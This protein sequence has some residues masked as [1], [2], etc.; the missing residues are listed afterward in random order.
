[1]KKDHTKEIA[2][3]ILNYDNPA[4]AIREYHEIEM[5]GVL[6]KNNIQWFI[7]SAI[8]SAIWLTLIFADKTPNKQVFKACKTSADS[9]N[10][11][12]SLTNFSY[13]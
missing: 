2:D 11:V 12:D 5:N 1:M 7:I 9:I 3:R 13:E 4:Q 10:V 8:Y 6:Q